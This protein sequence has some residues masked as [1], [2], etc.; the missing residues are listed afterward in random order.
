MITLVNLTAALQ[1]AWNEAEGERTPTQ[2]P[3][4]SLDATHLS[5]WYEFWITQ[6]EQPPQREPGVETLTVLLDLH[7]FSRRG[8]K[9][10]VMEMGDRVR[11][12]YSRRALPFVAGTDGAVREG[13]IR[14]RE[15]EVRDLTRE[16]SGVISLPLQHLVVSCAGRVELPVATVPSGE[17]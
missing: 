3:G 5:D 13:I 7:C 2:F 17:S 14:L 8:D 1:L 15:A 6:I 16:T 4:M 9:R 10:H 12:V 11:Q